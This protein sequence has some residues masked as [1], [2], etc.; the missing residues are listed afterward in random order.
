MKKFSE[1]IANHPKLVLL[2]MTLLLIPSIIGYKAT[3]IN[4]DI[5]SYLPTDLKSTQGQTILDKDFKNAATGMLILKG[6]DND[7]EK[8]REEVQKI[9]GVEDVISKTSILGPT[10]PNE[11]LPDD[12]RDVFYAKDST[13]MMVKFSESSSSMR[14]MKAIERI[15]QIESKEKYLS[16]ISAL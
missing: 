1:F 13:L 12:I 3:T 9:D 11:F 16:G 5:L 2:V 14:T 8:L 7:A 10:V 6:T 4:Y 15:K